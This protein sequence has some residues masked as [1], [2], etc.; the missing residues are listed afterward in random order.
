MQHVA[1]WNLKS[2]SSHL[3][4]CGPLH[5]SF[6]GNVAYHAPTSNKWQKN[7]KKNKNKKMTLHI[8][9]HGAMRG[10]GLTSL[11]I[12]IN[13]KRCDI[14]ER[15]ATTRSEIWT[16]NIRSLGFWDIRE[17]EIL[18]RSILQSVGFTI[19]R[20]LICQKMELNMVVLIQS[21]KIYS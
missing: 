12:C 5:L 14:K 18:W 4:W 11:I 7:K 2:Y 9:T 16:T 15:Y 17:W 20:D 21:V 8:L 1:L 6:L 3:H 13:D 10:C 19:V